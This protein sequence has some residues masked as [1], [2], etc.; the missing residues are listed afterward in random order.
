VEHRPLSSS[1]G[2]FLCAE[3][4][5]LL[6]ASADGHMLRGPEKSRS[7]LHSA[8]GTGPPYTLSYQRMLLI[9]SVVGCH[10][11]VVVIDAF[12]IVVYGCMIMDGRIWMM[13]DDNG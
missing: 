4:T 12:A 8:K 9:V 5:A 13:M 2:E 3:S 6:S 1:A 7:N 10:V 11:V